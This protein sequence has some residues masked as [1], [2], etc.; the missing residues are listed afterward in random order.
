[1][2]SYFTTPLFSIQEAADSTASIPNVNPMKFTYSPNAPVLSSESKIEK[3]HSADQIHS[4]ADSQYDR[5]MYLLHNYVQSEVEYHDELQVLRMIVKSFNPVYNNYFDGSLKDITNEMVA[6]RKEANE[7]LLETIDA[8]IQKHTEMRQILSLYSFDE[9]VLKLSTWG[10]NVPQLYSKYMKRYRLDVSQCK[11]EIKSRRRPLIRVRYLNTFYKNLKNILITMG[12]RSFSSEAIPSFE[13]IIYKLTKCLEECRKLDD[14][15]KAKCNDIVTISTAKDVLSLQNVCVIIEQSQ[16]KKSQQYNVDL[17]YFNMIEHSTLTYLKATL[18]FLQNGELAIVE[19]E[20]YNKSLVFAQLRQGEFRYSKSDDMDGNTSLLF[21]H[22]VCGSRVQLCFTI[23]QNETRLSNLLTGLFPPQRV[24]LRHIESSKGLGIAPQRINEISTSP[25]STDGT[26]AN[27]RLSSTETEPTSVSSSG[28]E[29]EEDH[30]LTFVQQTQSSAPLYKLHLETKKIPVQAPT[31]KYHTELLQD[32][33]IPEAPANELDIQ[34]EREL[35]LK[36]M[37]QVVND[38]SSDEEEEEGD[39]GDSDGDYDVQSCTNISFAPIQQLPTPIDDSHPADG[40]TIT[41]ADV[42]TEEQPQHS[43]FRNKKHD[44]SKYENAIHDVSQLTPH[45]SQTSTQS[46]QKKKSFF[47]TFTSILSKKREVKSSSR[48]SSKEL[49]AT[50]RKSTTSEANAMASGVRLQ[51]SK[52]ETALKRIITSDLSTTFIT[53]VRICLWNGHTWSNAKDCSMMLHQQP[54]SSEFY[55]GFYDSTAKS[56]SSTTISTLGLSDNDAINLPVLLMRLNTLSSCTS[57]PIDIQM[58]AE[59]HI[60]N[61]LTVL[62]RPSDISE[63]TLINN[64]LLTPSET[65]LY[66]QKNESTATELSIPNSYGMSIPKVESM[67]SIESEVDFVV[68]GTLEKLK[69]LTTDD[70]SW[71]GVG[72]LLEVIENGKEMDLNSCVLTV[73]NRKS[74]DLITIDLTGFEFGNIELSLR[75]HEI[76]EISSTKI[77]LGENYILQ[78]ENVQ[79]MHLFYECVY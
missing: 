57:N 44:F 73:E 75:Q 27:E 10:E 33:K 22:S 17:H 19:T 61:K 49:P 6:Y 43:I 9:L 7:E 5:L 20:N 40:Q 63:L 37:R 51:K 25:V 12:E 74:R 41:K 32:T 52:S 78:L 29:S 15:E 47:N 46:Q 26:S 11:S 67:S 36:F 21:N 76:K 55:I 70:K 66:L 23:K 1:M 18:M 56:L 4:I 34:K 16:F 30:E 64:A 28:S 59:N 39:E 13:V 53:R 2:P 3:F 65:R 72:Q 38:I 42:L 50:V 35:S 8:I 68:E 31:S 24:N 45:A 79:D 77:S 71:T 14:V 62:I 69:T 58:V 48:K 54:S 60:G